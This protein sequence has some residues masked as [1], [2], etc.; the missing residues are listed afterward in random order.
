V[1]INLLNE[2]QLDAIFY[3]EDELAAAEKASRLPE[4]RYSDHCALNE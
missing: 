1:N 4:L 3:N 2:K